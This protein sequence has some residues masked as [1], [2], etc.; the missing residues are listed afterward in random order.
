MLWTEESQQLDPRSTESS[1]VADP[2]G[3]HPGLIGYQADGPVPHQ[4][5]AIR[6][7]HVDAHPHVRLS[8]DSL[9]RSVTGTGTTHATQDTQQDR[10]S[11]H[12]KYL[13]LAVI[14]LW[15]C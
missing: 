13:A 2:L 9:D 8:T 7:Q 3:V 4:L 1:D 6:Q 14:S 12:S 10:E 15:A 11:V 5:K